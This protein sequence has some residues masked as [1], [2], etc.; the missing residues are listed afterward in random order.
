MKKTKK[1]RNEQTVVLKKWRPIML[2]ED[3]ENRPF[4]IG[5]KWEDMTWTFLSNELVRV[6]A[7]GI[8]K[9]Y[10][11]SDLGFTDRRKGDSPD[12]RWAILSKLAKNNGEITWKT[13]INSKEK[14]MMSAAVRDIRKRLKDFFNIDDDPFH[15]YRKTKSYKTKFTIKDYRHYENTDDYE[16][17]DFS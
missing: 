8:S 5:T 4:P 1:N 13:N 2:S 11:Y 12:T 14:N 17:E 3:S 15:P 9:K 7:K 10:Q 6:E 16:S